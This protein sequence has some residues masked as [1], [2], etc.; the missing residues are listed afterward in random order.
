MLFSITDRSSS[1]LPFLQGG[2]KV[3]LLWAFWVV[4]CFIPLAGLLPGR[5]GWEW[6]SFFY[7]SSSSVL[8]SLPGLRWADISILC[9]ISK[10]PWSLFSDLILKSPPPPRQ[11]PRRKST[12]VKKIF[13][14]LLSLLKSPNFRIWEW[15][16]DLTRPLWVLKFEYWSFLYAV[17]ITIAPLPW[18]RRNKSLTL[19]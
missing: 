14:K 19:M 5:E 16:A 17:Q 15:E 9:I 11:F 8:R 7:L 12:W 3:P 6:N 13:S 2:R 10:P 18:G 4:P 1:L